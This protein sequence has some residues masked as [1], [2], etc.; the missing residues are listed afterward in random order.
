VR[1]RT[2]RRL[3]AATAAAGLALAP[4]A[5]AWADEPARVRLPRVADALAV[6]VDIERLLYGPQ[7]IETRLPGP[8]ADEERVRTS[9]DLGGAPVAIS[10]DQRMELSGLGDFEFKIAGPATDVE[11]LPGSETEPGL[12]R[13]SV[14]W[15]GFSDGSKSIGARM[16]LIP[17]QEEIRLPVRIELAMT[18]G[19]E[20]VRPGRPVSG[21]LHLRLTLT[22]NSPLPIQVVD[23]DI[24]LKQGAAILD[25]IRSQVRAGR[26]P[27]PGEDGVP[28]AVHLTNASFRTTD[29][30][31]PI[32]TAGAIALPARRIVMEH[33]SG[34][35]P[36]GSPGTFRFG[37]LL[38]GGEPLGHTVE[39]TARVRDLRLPKILV[40]A[41]SGLP[42]TASLAPPAGGSWSAGVRAHP[43][44][45]EPGEMTALIMDTMWRTARL[46]QFDA[47]LGDPDPT[48]PAHTA[49]RFELAPPAAAAAPEA[50]ATSGPLRTIAGAAVALV[51]VLGGLVVWSR[52]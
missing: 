48:G 45:F 12:R 37:T 35:G 16:H 28:R 21:E 7:G 15:Q 27:V 8:V 26:R 4:L 46:R 24:D 44:A 31:A 5:P 14:L 52:S 3:C 19:G 40:T 18:V 49:Y 10:V 43:S 11:S 17:G 1:I 42:S 30:E 34:A 39:L 9:F 6:A 36:G 50:Q 20:P 2:L 25:A 38:G 32:R 47:Y 41:E 33:V 13:G 51:L 23:G 22:N 29:L